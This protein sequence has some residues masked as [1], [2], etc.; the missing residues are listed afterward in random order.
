M[1][2]LFISKILCFLLSYQATYIHP[3]SCHGLGWL[4]PEYMGAHISVPRFYSRTNSFLKIVPEPKPL[5]CNQ[6]KIVSVHYSLN[7]DA[8]RGN[9]NINFF[10]LVSLSWWILGSCLSAKHS[11]LELVHQSCVPVQVGQSRFA[12]ECYWNHWK[13]TQKQINKQTHKRSKAISVSLRLE[14]LLFRVC[15]FK[16]LIITH[17][18]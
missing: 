10:Y 18:K 3:K 7:S 17:I 4:T 2:R 8:Y 11:S 16:Y 15:Q 14:N 9:S 13:Q 1:K 5:R 12:G 6:Q